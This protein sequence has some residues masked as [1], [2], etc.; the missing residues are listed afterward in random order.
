MINLTIKITANTIE[1]GLNRLINNLTNLKP[2]LIKI[3]S[4]VVSY[5]E[6]RFAGEQDPKN[7]PWAQ[8]RPVTIE[9]RHNPGNPILTDIGTLRR[10]FVANPPAE[11]S[12][13]IG[14]PIRYATTQQYG[15]KKG[16][17]GTYTTSKG[18]TLP[19]PWGDIPARPILPSVDFPEDLANNIRNIF[20]EIYNINSIN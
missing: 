18:A 8:L 9:K 11:N 1:N 16:Q 6:T 13:T 2:F 17:F 12:I 10:S 3:G 19:I 20:K 4:A 7:N 14:S 15:A 5:V